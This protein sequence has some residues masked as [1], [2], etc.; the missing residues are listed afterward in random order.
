MDDPHDLTPILDI[1]PARASR[2]L[3]EPVLSARNKSS[4]LMMH[5]GKGQTGAASPASVCGAPYSLPAPC[6]VT[7]PSLI[8]DSR[9][10]KSRVTRR[11]PA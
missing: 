8:I 3:S 2:S 7:F 11:S 9:S 1:T 10:L 6:S 5:Y 4:R